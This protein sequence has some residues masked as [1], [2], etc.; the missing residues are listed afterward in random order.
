MSEVIIQE[1]KVE[2]PFF[3]NLILDVLKKASKGSLEIVDEIGNSHYFGKAQVADSPVK[4]KI[5]SA[6][7]YNRCV[8]YGDIGF[9]ESY[10]EGLWDTDN[11]TE[12]IKFMILNKDVIG[13]QSGSHA[14]RIALN[15]LGSMNRFAHSLRRNTYK[16]SKKNISYHYDLSNDFYSLWLDPSMT[17]S[18]GIF[19]N[20][21]TSL[22]EA[23][24]LKYQRLCDQLDVSEGEHLLEIGCGWGGFA[25]Y[26]ALNYGAKITSITI[27]KEQYKY[28]KHRIESK[29]LSKLVNVEL[30]DYRD[31]QGT[32]D[33]AVSIEMIEAVGHDYLELFFKSIYNCLKPSGVLALQ[34]IT[35]P[36]SYYE[37]FRK[38]VDWIQKHI[39]PGSLLNST[40]RLIEASSKTSDFQLYNFF[41]MGL[42]YA[43]TLRIWRNN[44]FKN[45]TEIKEL[46]F[47]E[48]FA[49]K[50]NYY[51]SYCEAAFDTR[52]ISAAQ[53]TFVR[54][55]GAAPNTPF[56][57]P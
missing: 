9:G 23:Q 43:Q 36:D 34:A 21:D 57:N 54:P 44:F 1:K 49:R 35:S 38:G 46:G 37:E 12:V 10:V 16:G 56:S 48:S 27:S 51:L 31:V 25:E 2:Q 6:S 26:V 7:F 11:V 13:L 28:A 50:W 41:D 33:K 8:L 15:A 20:K 45:L 39:F 55:N 19:L 24:K 22:E 42:H 52:N 14:R 18:C 17:Y 30:C 3:K 40:T 4:V 32:Y 47:D 53:L 29:G 5:L